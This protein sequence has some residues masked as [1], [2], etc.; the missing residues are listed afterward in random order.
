LGGGSLYGAMLRRFHKNGG[1]VKGMVW[2]QGCSDAVSECSEVYSRR[3][4]A[5]IKSTRRDFCSPQLPILTVQIARHHSRFSCGAVSWNDVQEQQRLLGETV[6]NCVTVPT[7]DLEVDDGIHLNGESQIR[8]GKRLVQAASALLKIEKGEK[9]PIRLRGIGFKTDRL[10]GYMDIEVRFSNVIGEL[11]SKGRA[12]GFAVSDG[13]GNILNMIY[14]AELHGN[15]VLL[16]TNNMRSEIEGMYLHYGMGTAAYCNVTDLEDRSLPGFMICPTGKPRVVT[17]FVQE[18]MISG[19]VECPGSINKV[20]RPVLDDKNLQWRFRRFA[21]VNLNRRREVGPGVGGVAVHYLFRVYCPENMKLAICF[22]HD[23]SVKVWFDRTM[24]CQE[25][26]TVL[27]PE[28]DQV[29][30]PHNAR[31]GMH[32]VTV[33]LGMTP[34]S[35]GAFF[36]RLERLDIR[37]KDLEC[38]A[39]DHVLPEVVNPHFSRTKT[40]TF[41]NSI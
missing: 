6:D 30:A 32:D 19:P 39:C 23:G 17:P 13:R 8:L 20:K 12:A 36:V 22:G 3:M 27:L 35:N 11:V 16:K 37:P 38:I 14:K 15:K 29:R 21:S 2:Y 28:I 24:I 18:F 25:S 5:F 31:K 7:V 4:R 40:K 1:K 34:E 9:L 33:S 26:G 10:S 41:V